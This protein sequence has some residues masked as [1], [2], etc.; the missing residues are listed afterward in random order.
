MK[1]RFNGPCLV[2]LALA[3]PVQAEEMEEVVV[4]TNRD[5]RTIDVIETLS[6][7]PDAAQ[8]LREAPGAN[9]NSNGPLT[10]IP[11]YR[12]M[13]GPR[14]AVSV[15]GSMLAPAGPNWMDPPLSYAMTA[16][17]ESL[18]IYRGIAPVSVAQEAVGGVIDAQT[19]RGEFGDSDSFALSGRVMGSGQSVSNGYQADAEL[20]AS[21]RQHRLK[22]AAMTQGGDDAEFPEGDISPTEYERQ[23]YDVGYGFRSGE[24]T[25]QFD[26][27]YHDTGDSGTPALPM[28]IQYIEGD[29]YDV[30]YTYDGSSQLSG[31]VSLFGSELDHGMTNYQLRTAPGPDRWRRNIADSSNRGFTAEATWADNNGAWRTGIDGFKENH[32]SDIDNPKMPGFFVVNFNNAQREVLGAYLER[33]IEAWESWQAHM[34]IRYNRATTDSGKVDGT[35]AMMMPPAQA[36]RDAF[37]AADRSQTDHNLDLVLQLKYDLSPALQTYVGAAQKNRSPSYQERYLWLPLEATGGLADGQLY[38]GNIDLNPETVSQVEFGIDLT[39]ATFSLAPRV[40]YNRVDDYIQGMPLAMSS[41]AVMMN[42]MMNPAR[43]SALQFNNVDAELYGFDM[44][45]HWQ[46]DDNWA[47]SGLVN[48]V[49]GK[50]RDIDDDLYR[51]APPNTSVRLNYSAATWAASFESV[52][53]ASQD[54]VSA[55]N[56]EQTSAGYGLVNLSGKWQVLPSVQLAAGVDNALDK[57]FEDHLGGYNRAINPDINQGDRLPGYGRNLFARV[58]YTF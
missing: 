35:P 38:V 50:R 12:G 5:S 20:L 21:N 52:L 46:L 36:L 55:T 28:D 11:Q 40:F 44:D 7:A 1:I 39:Y 25:V 57:H 34:G 4:S 32:D 33:D 22:L 54:D 10:A 56:Q 13:F 48:Y 51:I 17:L 47:L 31:A 45:W 26:Y 41:P 42:N 27:G 8:L 24:H 2:V 43:S 15:N 23:R 29:L 49:R 18:E 19:R 6:V 58:L 3:M 53:Y 37:N 14:I 30:S 16:Q 9:V